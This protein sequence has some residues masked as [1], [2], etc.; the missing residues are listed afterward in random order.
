LIDEASARLVPKTLPADLS[1]NTVFGVIDVPNVV[2]A[3]SLETGISEQD[4]ADGKS[5]PE[6]LSQ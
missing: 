5:V 4:I 2:A 6:R 1:E 3:L